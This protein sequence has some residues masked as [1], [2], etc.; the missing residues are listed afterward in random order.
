M[1]G[2]W[3]RKV[4]F[5]TLY[6]EFVQVLQPPLPL[7]PPFHTEHYSSSYIRQVKSQWKALTVETAA[8]SQLFLRH[9]R[10]VQDQGLSIYVSLQ[11][12]HLVAASAFI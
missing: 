4:I 5:S 7:A 9:S 2:R 10:Y 6:K 8:K 11:I 12:Q 1:A 3:V